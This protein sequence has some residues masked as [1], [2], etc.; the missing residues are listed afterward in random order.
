M[1]ELWQATIAWVNANPGWMILLV[2]VASLGESIFLFGLLIPGALLMF[3]AGAIVGT[4]GEPGLLVILAAGVAGALLGDG[5]SY[6]L[7]RRFRN[8]L[9]GMWPMSRYPKLIDRGE[10]FFARHG[11]KSIIFGRFVGAV[12]PIVPTVAGTAGMKPVN[13]VIVDIIAALGWAPTYIVPGVVFAASLD[14]AAA[15]ASRLVVVILVVAISVW[16]AIW[17]S[18]WTV[19]WLAGHT[20]ELTTAL[21]DWSARHRRLG[22]LGSSLTDPRQPETPGLAI[23]AAILLV[24]G[25]LSLTLL[26]HGD[27]PQPNALD[28]FIYQIL[29]DLRTS[30]VDVIA[31]ALAQ[32]GAVEVY[33]PLTLAVLIGL[34]SF[35]RYFA[36]AHWAAAIGFA[37][38]VAL[39]VNLAMDIPQPVDYYSAIPTGEYAGGHIILGTAVYGFL[40]V[41]LSSRLKPA[42]RWWFYTPCLILIVLMALARLYL[43]AQWFS[44]TLIGVGLGLI[45]VALLTLG[46]R[47]RRRQSVPVAPLSVVALS[48]LIAAALLQWNLSLE[49]D[50]RAYRHELASGSMTPA[51]WRSGGFADLPARLHDIEGRNTQPLNIQWAGQLTDIRARLRKAGWQKTHPLTATNTLLWLSKKPDMLHL[52]LLPQVHDGQYEALLMMRID[53]SGQAWVIRLWPSH[54]WI[55]YDNQSPSDKNDQ[56][57]DHNGL[58][59]GTPLWIGSLERYAPRTLAVYFTIPLPTGELPTEPPIAESYFQVIHPLSNESLWLISQI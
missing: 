49:D 28:A 3:L 44:D 55:A 40:A 4:T 46:Y 43:G 54:W 29:S 12:R 6:W 42:H 52:P 22:R 31:V 57:S 8:D 7:G 9:R 38:I 13:F 5:F 45:W 32:L 1:Q 20:E 33:L 11:G 37:A 10:R 58:P 21:L 59:V 17:V 25:W 50:L 36:A 30:G 26:W 35:E 18:R 53:E 41:L 56:F 48:A 34:L 24:A 51:Q 14:L 47:H 39:G 16:L 2:F 23:L 27:S 15:V 19:Q